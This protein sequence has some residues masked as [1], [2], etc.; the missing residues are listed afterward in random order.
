MIAQRSGSIVNLGS[1]YSIVAAPNRLSYCATKAAVA[2]MTRCLAIEWAEHGVRVNAIA[3]GYV[4]TALI[5]ALVLEKRIDIQALEQ[6][7]PQKRLARPEEIADA[8]LYLCEPRSAHITGQ[9]LAVDGG[10]SA[11]GY[12]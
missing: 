7:T 3:P 12:L 1:I 5:E 6:R 8:V 9:V 10:W 4:R 11:Y 2:M